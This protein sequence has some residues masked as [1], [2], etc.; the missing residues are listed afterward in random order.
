MATI[1]Q[2]VRKP[3]K[4][5]VVKNIACVAGMS[6]ASWSLHPRLYN[7]AK[8]AEFRATQSVPGTPNQRI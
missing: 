4:R 1:S 5:K 3:R 6:S 2:L 8:E 7:Y